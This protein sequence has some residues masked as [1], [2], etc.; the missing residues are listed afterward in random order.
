MNAQWHF[1]H[2]ILTLLNV[3]LKVCGSILLWS[4]CRPVVLPSQTKQLIA[5]YAKAKRIDV[6]VWWTLFTDAWRPASGNNK[7]NFV[8]CKLVTTKS[9]N[10]LSS[11]VQSVLCGYKSNLSFCKILSRC[12]VLAKAIYIGSS[13]FYQHWAKFG[14]IKRCQIIIAIKREA[15]GIGENNRKTMHNK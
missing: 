10:H 14:R 8:K 2:I 6:S 1:F 7:N 13:S 15:S 12:D 11:S 9:W 5:S 4:G 3:V